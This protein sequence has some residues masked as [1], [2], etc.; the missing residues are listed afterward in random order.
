MIGCNPSSGETLSE[1][2]SFQEVSERLMTNKTR[3]VSRYSPDALNVRISSIFDVLYS[4]LESAFDDLR[5]WYKLLYNW[6]VCGQLQFI[7]ARLATI[8]WCEVKSSEKNDIPHG[9]PV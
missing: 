7:A 2:S 1:Q 6:V 4:R 9:R 3:F 5:I 8:P